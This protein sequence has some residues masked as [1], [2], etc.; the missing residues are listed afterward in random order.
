VIGSSGTKGV[1][2]VA[3]PK[4]LLW[5]EDGWQVY[6]AGQPLVDYTIIQDENSTYSTSPI[7]TAQKQS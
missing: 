4:P 7:L 5:V 2:Q 6:I 1:C 3:I